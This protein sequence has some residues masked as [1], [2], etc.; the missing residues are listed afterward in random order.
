MKLCHRHYKARDTLRKISGDH[1]QCPS[2]AYVTAKCLLV[3]CD[4]LPIGIDLWRKQLVCTA[5]G[6]L[7]FSSMYFGLKA[8][9]NE[10]TTVAET[11]SMQPH[12]GCIECDA[13]TTAASFERNL[14][15]ENMLTINLYAFVIVFN[16][17]K[18][19]YRFV[20]RKT[21]LRLFF[22]HQIY[23]TGE[24]FSSYCEF[25]LVGG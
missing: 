4:I 21:I 11:H 24:Y 2:V 16:F 17:N 10:A 13:V 14:E 25:M 7:K 12:F 18:F 3:N 9:S 6:Y 19:K 1:R 15:K 5:G 8:H 20:H 23:G 22:I